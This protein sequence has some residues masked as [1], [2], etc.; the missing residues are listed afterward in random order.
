MVT[1]FNLLKTG[2]M[3]SAVDFCF[4]DATI[5]Q[6]DSVAVFLRPGV[7][8]AKRKRIF[9]TKRKKRRITALT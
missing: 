3:Y 5:R 2:T 4:V 6:A 8:A 9:S 1:K 7:G